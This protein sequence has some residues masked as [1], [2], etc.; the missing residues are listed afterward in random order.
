MEKCTFC[1]QRIQ[2]AEGIAADENRPVRDGEIRPAC[3]QACPA[4]AIVFGD[5]TDPASRV[6]LLAGS[7]RAFRLLE[8]L[9]TKPRVIYLAADTWDARPGGTAGRE[10]HDPDNGPR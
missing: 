4:E 3:A 6:S 10:G 7:R 8:E 5:A 1:I 9:G 2:K